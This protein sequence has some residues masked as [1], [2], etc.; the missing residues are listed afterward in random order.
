[1]WVPS[2]D[3]V[4]LTCRSDWC[5]AHPAE[6]AGQYYRTSKPSKVGM[7]HRPTW[8]SSVLHQT[9][10]CRPHSATLQLNYKKEWRK[11][12]F[13]FLLSGRVLSS[14]TCDE[15]VSMT[16]LD[17]TRRVTYPPY[18]IWKFGFNQ[19][20]MQGLHVNFVLDNL[21]NY[22][23]DYYYSNSPATIGIT[24]T[25][26]ISIDVDQFFNKGKQI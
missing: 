22:V 17:E 3:W 10:R 23:P 2:S 1:M 21:F 14:V 15:Y 5:P 20:I 7:S 12:G 6:W 24:F 8:N 19:K 9:D 26:S 4:L 25:S 13:S 18:T 11:Y 16:S